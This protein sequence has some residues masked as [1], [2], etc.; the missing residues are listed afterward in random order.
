MTDTDAEVR[1]DPAN[2]PGV[3]NLLSILAASTGVDDPA[4]LATKYT[5]YG[6]LK[7]DTAA[8]LVEFLR[9]LQARY[10]ELDEDRAEMAAILRKGADKATA[11]ASV[12]C[13]RAKRNIGL[14]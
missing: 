5:Q 9:P 10:K 4:T 14:L 7:A 13:E 12:V 2:K 6:P 11:V 8:A 1:F 3:S